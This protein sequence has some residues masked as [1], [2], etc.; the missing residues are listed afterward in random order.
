MFEKKEQEAENRRRYPA[1]ATRRRF[2]EATQ[3][4]I[5]VYQRQKAQAELHP[6]AEPSRIATLGQVGAPDPPTAYARD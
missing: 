2:R 5:E 6:G 3:T 4:L 1:L